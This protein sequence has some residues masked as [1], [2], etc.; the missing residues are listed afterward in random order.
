MTS[1]P[2]SKPE[3]HDSALIKGEIVPISVCH[4]EILR[5]IKHLAAQEGAP[6]VEHGDSYIGSTKPCYFIRTAL[7]R[8]MAKDWIRRHPELAPA[9]YLDLFDSLAQGESSNEFSFVGILVEYLPRTRQT[10]EPR[11]L[12]RWLERAEGWEEVDSICQSTFT[13]EEM[14]ANWKEWKSLLVSLSKSQNVHKRRASL[15]LLTKPLRESADPR[16]ARLAFANIGKLKSDKDI[17][18]TKAISWLLR[19]L[20]KY[21]RQEVENYLK[22]NSDSLPKIALRETRNKL[23]SGRKSGRM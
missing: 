5:E 9:D 12:D 21:H 3:F 7:V 17:L 10:L 14:L 13:A 11:H 16:L 8:R 1:I 6:Y 19:A 4:R 22:D 20:I 2:S 15:V 18:I 23:K